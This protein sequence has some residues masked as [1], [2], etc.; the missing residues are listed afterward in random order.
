MSSA[1]QKSTWA[2]VFCIDITLPSHYSVCM[3]NEM[4]PGSL[5]PPHEVRDAEKLT[6][7]TESMRRDGWM[8]EPLLVTEAGSAWTGSHRIAAAIAAGLEMVPVHVVVL[9]E[10]QAAALT[11]EVNE[12]FQPRDQESMLC[13]LEALDGVDQETMRLYRTECAKEAG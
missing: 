5:I 4:R 3:T 13:A 11:G 12:C 9:T 1:A 7:L 2:S 8:G 10:T 6:I